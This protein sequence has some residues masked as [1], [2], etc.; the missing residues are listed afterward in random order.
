VPDKKF[1]LGDYVEVKDRIR[2]FYESY[3]QGR[4]VTADYALT[5]EPDDKPK[6]I[7]TALAYRSPDDPY[8]GRGTSWMYLPGTTS[9]TRGSEIEN[10]ETSAW[11][12]AIGSLGILIDRS[13]ATSNE[14]ENKSGDEAKHV[15]KPD[16]E[17]AAIRADEPELIGPWSGTGAFGINKKGP[18][19]G[20]L[21][22]EPDGAVVVVT[23]TTTGEHKIP[24]VVIRG[25]LALDFLDSAGSDLAGLLATIEGEL[26]RVP[27]YVGD[28]KVRRE[29]ERLEVHK[30][31]TPAWTLPL[32]VADTIPL[33]E[34][35]MDRAVAA[36]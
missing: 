2:V 21:R 22:Q 32:A 30:I 27:F 33:F 28:K 19:D 11:G 10:V 36:I 16:P 5:K 13:I 26:Y 14:I 9:Y 12:R 1:D 6:V 34:D 35:E 24:Q 17:K 4:L 7:V 20:F 23:F 29:F 15:D 18:A 31:T 8:P 3:G 25:S